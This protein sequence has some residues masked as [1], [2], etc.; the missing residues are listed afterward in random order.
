MEHNAEDAATPLAD[1]GLATAATTDSVTEVVSQ[2]TEMEMPK[3]IPEPA[4]SAQEEVQVKTPKLIYGAR[5]HQ[6]V[7]GITGELKKRAAATHVDATGEE[8]HPE[9]HPS[10]D[11][12]GA[13]GAVTEPVAGQA[14]ELSAEKPAIPV[15]PR[16]PPKI[17]PKAATSTLQPS[18]SP[19]AEVT[20]DISSTST[21]NEPRATLQRR[22]T[23]TAVAG[24]EMH[25][26]G[27]PVPLVITKK[28]AID[29]SNDA[30]V[31]EV[32]IWLGWWRQFF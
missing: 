13:E 5:P 27:A 21:E 29:T 23:G 7:A 11:I 8:H 4:E 6:M 26:D 24:P 22:T 31:E 20:A 14:A 25:W 32:S 15:R 28:S 12:V 10:E 30:V 1:A 16:L 18:S 9:E 3:G 2:S 19:S 17:P